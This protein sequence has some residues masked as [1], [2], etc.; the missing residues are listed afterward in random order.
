MDAGFVFIVRWALDDA[1]DKSVVSAVDALHALIV[2]SDDEVRRVQVLS[3]SL[4]LCHYFVTTTAISR[5][6]YSSAFVSRHTS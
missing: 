4:L 5:P 2:C 1:V 6:L 3:L